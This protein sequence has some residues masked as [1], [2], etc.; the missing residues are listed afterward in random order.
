MALLCSLLILVHPPHSITF[1]FVAV[2]SENTNRTLLETF[3]SSN[4]AYFIAKHSETHSEQMADDL[5][6]LIE[7]VKAGQT[8]AYETVVRRFQNMAVGYAYACLGDFQLAEDA[9]QETFIVAYFELPTL[10]EPGAFPGW[11]R[12]ILIKQI[13]RVRRKRSSDFAYDDQLNLTSNALTPPEAFE[14]A[15]AQTTIWQAIQGLQPA[16]R[17][18][19]LLFYIDEYSQQ[20]VSDFLGVPLTTVKMRLYHARKAL[21]QQLIVRL[22]DGLP[23][24]RPSRNNQFTEKIMSY[25]V[26]TKHVPALTVMS[27]SRQVSQK[28]LQSHLDNSIN[29]MQALAEANHVQLAGL[30][31]SIYYGVVSESQEALVEVCLPIMQP[32]EPRGEVKVRQLSAAEAASTTLTMRQSIFPGVVKAYEVVR[33]W[34]VN[35]GHQPG[36][37]Q[38]VYL[39][40]NRSIFSPLAGWDDPCVE[41]VWSYE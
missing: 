39:N 7:A 23:H 11:F 21:Q 30:P 3:H 5:A 32:V 14:H 38:E 15:Q 40:F 25:E 9:A 13:D 27:I 18:V 16:Q 1:R 28:E 20:D 36:N 26:Q 12:R 19:V 22:E 10:R 37:P 35:Q 8:E 33:E 41:I 17:E 24:H 34:I 2:S 4:G 6:A 29:V 31:R